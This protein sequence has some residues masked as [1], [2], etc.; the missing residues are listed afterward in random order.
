MIAWFTSVEIWYLILLLGIA[1]LQVSNL[2]QS[3][4]LNLDM[5]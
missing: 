4:L 2:K 1:E 5:G 3:S